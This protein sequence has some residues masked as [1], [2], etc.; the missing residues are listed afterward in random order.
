[1][2]TSKFWP[3]QRRSFEKHCLIIVQTILLRFVKANVYKKMFNT[4]Y[5]V[6]ISVAGV[7]TKEMCPEQCGGSRTF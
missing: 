2:G 4:V 7:R 6:I 5:L 1:M 3:K